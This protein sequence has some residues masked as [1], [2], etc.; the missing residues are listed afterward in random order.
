ME[1]EER[2]RWSLIVA[3]L[4]AG[5]GLAWW[6]AGPGE[7]PAPAVRVVRELP[8]S[9][10][11]APARAPD[12]WALQASLGDL[13]ERVAALDAEVK[14]LRQQL[15]T[16][17]AQ[18]PA[19][20]TAAPAAAAM[21]AEPRARDDPAAFAEAERATVTA[22]ESTFR[23]EAT[24]PRWSRENAALLQQALTA[25]ASGAV[26][27]GAVECRS[28]T[29]RVEIPDDG[30][31]EAGDVLAL[32]SERVGERLPTLSSARIEQGNGSA[33]TVLYLSP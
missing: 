27:V 12:A 6:L 7:E 20:S 5:S 3:A 14:A 28:R 25:G 4:L 24:D 9:H 16:A 26:R 22:L 2:G 31:G 15:A 23:R 1:L 33:T 32:L 30:S 18:A 10:P 11:L 21:P 13:Q 29:C 19:G 8:A 17:R